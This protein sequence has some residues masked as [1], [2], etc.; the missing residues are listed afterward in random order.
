LARK[1]SSVL[2]SRSREFLVMKIKSIKEITVDNVGVTIHINPG[3]QDTSV[4][5]T[6]TCPD[7]AGWGCRRHG[8]TSGGNPDCH[9]G[10]VKT[11]LNPSKIDQQLDGE[12]AMKIKAAVQNLSM[13]LNGD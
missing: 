11:K 8:S 1:R 3:N 12:T 5:L 4:V 9:G 13:E 7:C 10:T 6:Y 2:S